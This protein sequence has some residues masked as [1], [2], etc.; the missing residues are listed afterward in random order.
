VAGSTAKAPAAAA[1]TLKVT[2]RVTFITLLTGSVS[3][4]T[5][6]ALHIR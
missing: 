6:T 3:L 4:A 5:C 2:D 1:V